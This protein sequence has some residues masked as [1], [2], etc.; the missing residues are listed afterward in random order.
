MNKVFVNKNGLNQ[1]EFSGTYSEEKALPLLCPICRHSD[2]LARMSHK[3][4]EMFIELLYWQEQVD[5]LGIENVPATMREDNELKEA[6][7]LLYQ[8]DPIF[9][10]KVNLFVE[11]I[12]A[13]LMKGKA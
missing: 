4:K 10:R 8:N 12:V 1:C 5:T 2:N 9:D 11:E 7:R 6:A 3:L 13:L